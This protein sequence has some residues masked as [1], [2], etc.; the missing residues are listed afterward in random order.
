ML[1]FCRIE[2]AFDGKPDFLVLECVENVRL[3]D[4]LVSFVLDAANNRTFL[5]VKYYDLGVRI[6]RAVLDFDPNI[7]KKLRVP[8]REEIAANRFVTIRITGARKDAR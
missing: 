4:G 5:D 1:D 8:Q 2:L 3:T 7:F 6:S